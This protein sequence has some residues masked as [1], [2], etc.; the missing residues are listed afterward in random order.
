MKDL[1]T[2][3]A[4]QTLL[5]NQQSKKLIAQNK[6]IYRFGFG[7]SPFMP[8]DFIAEAFRSAIHRKDYTHVQG[9]LPLR[10]AISG[11][12]KDA[13]GIDVSAEN[14]FVAPG[15]KIL[16]FSVL[17]SFTKADVLI[18]KPS[19]VSYA[20]Q[21]KLAGH[22]LIPIETGYDQRWRVKPDAVRKAATQKK[23]ETTIL[24]LNYPGNPDGLSYTK[25][26]IENLAKAVHDLDAL[27]ISDEIYAL[28]NHNNSHYSF[29]NAYQ[30]TV[31]TTGLS[32]WCGAGG[33]RLGAA[34]LSDGLGE[35]FKESMIGVASETYSCAPTPVQ[36][37][38]LAAY[39]SYAQIQPYL[40]A[41]INV[42]RQIGGF[43]YEKLS[44]TKIKLHAPEGAF[45]LLPD[46]SEYLNKLKAKNMH[47]SA[48]MCSQLLEDTGV[49][50]LPGSAFG[51]DPGYL[52]ARL[53]YVDFKD[54]L[55]TED[56]NLSRDCPRIVEGI[57]KICTW[58]DQL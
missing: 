52:A 15:S 40:S 34:L 26:E 24:I 31:T 30:K 33:W 35:K 12:H 4:S 50:L 21:A 20:P 58:V 9:E 48:A 3:E 7:E 11:F 6:N 41:Q 29:A 1:R 22:H 16:I 17:A 2:I 19:W 5:I 8:P 25:V 39:Q 47:T 45:Y 56:F 13:N 51:L 18:P 53:A 55:S 49:V 27:V 54:P 32:K 10:N 23:H 46:F 44:N 38:A 43:C 14:I 57:E 28:L 36:M 42:L 37:A